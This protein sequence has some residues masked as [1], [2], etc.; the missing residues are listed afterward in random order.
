MT[1]PRRIALLMSRDVSFYRDVIRGVRAYAVG[2]RNWVFQDGPP[3]ASVV[4]AFKQ[5]NP[6]G[7]I[8][9]LLTV[10]LARDV[11]RLGRPLVDMSCTVPNLDVP[12]VDVD[13]RA[14]GRL[15]AEHFLERGHWHFGFFGS[16]WAH[17][18]RLRE[19]SFRTRL[20]EAGF[21]V[22]S[23][24]IEYLLRL[25]A[26]TGW[27]HA[28][29]RVH[30]W[31]R[32]LPKPIGILASNDIPA[33][34][35][36]DA[37]LQLGIRVPD[38]V[39]LLGVDNDDL[40]CGLT[41]PPLSSVATPARQI[42]YEAAKL[43]DGLM[44]GRAAPREPV[45]LPPIGVVTRRSTDALAIDDPCV[46]AALDF[47]AKRIEGD[48][49]VEDVAQFA[50]IGRRTLEHRFRKILG[51]TVLQ[52]IRRTRIQR[53]KQLLSDTDLPMPAIARRSG[54]STPQRMAT[55]FRSETGLTPSQYR[56]QTQVRAD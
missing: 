6:H 37:C 30:G 8:A 4:R 18:S 56:R 32:E 28:R 9:E 1:E 52:E 26:L 38:E 5:W 13:H 22:S 25:P 12:V 15:A 7:T 34:D 20:A 39:A 16:E 54:F 10:D 53:V 14:V 21:S 48:I 47:I 42:G 17:F 36:A 40:E 31:L 24:Y 55:V 19:A 2:K 41:S 29:R 35:L 50:A 49:G 51:H 27:K 43:L 46:A 33:R 45:F 3:E 23:C 44:A 11:L